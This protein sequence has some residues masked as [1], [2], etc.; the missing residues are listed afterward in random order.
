MCVR[1]GPSELRFTKFGQGPKHARF[2][3]ANR[4]G[5]QYLG[6]WQGARQLGETKCE[7]S[8]NITIGEMFSELNGIEGKRS[9]RVMVMASG[10]KMGE[11]EI[12]L[13]RAKGSRMPRREVY[14][15]RAATSCSANINFI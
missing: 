3:G 5:D 1:E 10:G 13:V 11:K 15:R 12:W 4:E 9:V 8:N 7:D 14:V 2:R 6:R